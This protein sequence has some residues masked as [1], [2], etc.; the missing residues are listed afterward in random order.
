[1]SNG[2][3][4]GLCGGRLYGRGKSVC[5]GYGGGGAGDCDECVFGGGGCRTFPRRLGQGRS[6]P[7]R[8]DGE[9]NSPLQCTPAKR[10]ATVGGRYMRCGFTPWWLLA[11]SDVLR[12]RG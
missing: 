10:P 4:D 8:L 11:L 2:A 1:M 12:A 3:D 6:E 9:I 7:Q 5:G